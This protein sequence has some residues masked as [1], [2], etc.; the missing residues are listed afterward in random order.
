MPDG[1]HVLTAEDNARNLNKLKFSDAELEAALKQR[2]PVPLIAFS[3]Y[4]EP[5]DDLNPSFKIIARPLGNLSGRSPVEILALILPS[6]K[7]SFA[8][9]RIIKD[10]EPTMVSGFPAAYA[11]LSYTLATETDSYETTSELWIVPRG[12]HFFMLG[13]GTRTDEANGSRMEIADIVHSVRIE[14]LE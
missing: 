7:Q 14:P 12:S 5:H 1:W 4:Q 10:A 2:G 9:A 11:Q 13:A 6:L 3:K 8:D